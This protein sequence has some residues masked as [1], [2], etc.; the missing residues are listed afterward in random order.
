MILKTNLLGTKSE[1][2][3]TKFGI[4]IPIAF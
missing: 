2:K 1:R 3:L 4:Y